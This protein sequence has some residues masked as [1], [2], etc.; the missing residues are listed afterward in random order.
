MA[1]GVGKSKPILGLQ[2][3]F[4]GMFWSPLD[5]SGSSSYVAGGDVVSPQSFGFNSY[6][7]ELVGG[8]SQSGNYQAVPR[9]LNS[10]FT[11]WQL[12]WFVVSTGLQVG[13]GVNLSGETVRLAAIGQ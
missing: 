2:Q 10:G 9:A 5:I 13:A 8:V 12:M 3:T 11:Q 7:H 1:Q 4:G 6:I